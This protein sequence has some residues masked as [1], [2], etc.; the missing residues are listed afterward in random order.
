MPLREVRQALSFAERE[1]GIDRLLLRKDLLTSTGQLFLERYGSL[2]NLSASGQIAMRQVLK[3]YLR[4]VEWGDAD[5]PVRLFP[6]VLPESPTSDK[7]IA[8]D[9]AIAFGRPI[10]V[11]KGVTTAVIRDRVDAGE[12]VKELA[13][14]YGVG[15]R[16]IEQAVTYER[17]A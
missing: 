10:L 15:E 13:A 14:D 17:V 6:F 8:I 2:I 11:G 3:A 7:P 5:F 9:P 4:R 12:S 1:L 16:E